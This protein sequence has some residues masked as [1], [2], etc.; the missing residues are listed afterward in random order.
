MKILLPVIIVLLFCLLPLT[1]LSQEYPDTVF[2]RAYAVNVRSGPGL[3][4]DK[5]GVVF[6]NTR[7]KIMSVDNDWYEVLI[8]DT[9][10]GW[11]AKP[12]TSLTPVPPFERDVILFRDGEMPSK[13]KVIDR[14]ARKREGEEFAFMQDVVINHHQFEMNPETIKA[15]LSEIFRKWAEYEVV[16]AVSVLIYVIENDF[17]GQIAQNQDICKELKLAA[18]EALKILVRL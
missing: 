12:Y 4:Y 2:V 3:D 1:L 5:A 6:I 15:I 7:L 11:I 17:N 8:G 13:L 14:F 9:L 16:P 18:K 10:D